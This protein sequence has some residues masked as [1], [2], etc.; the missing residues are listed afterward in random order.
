MY[1]QDLNQFLV[2]ALA[3]LLAVISPGPDFALITRQSFLHGRKSSI[4]TSLGIASG[5]LVHVFY[6]IVGLNFLLTNNN[7]LFYIRI[8]CA[9]YLFYLGLSSIFIN[10][11]PDKI[12]DNNDSSSDKIVISNFKSFKIGFIT[13][14]LNLKATLFFL[15]LYSFILSSNPDTSKF[16]QLSYGIWMMLITGCW[17]M[18]VSWFLTNKFLEKITKDYYLIIN[19]VMGI[20]LI[21]IA[22]RLFID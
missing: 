3:H 14:I 22:I 17:F 9:I 6:C 12:E 2:I 4:Y 5:I 16:L 21:Y 20:V 19:R 7:I 15:S 10:Y 8:V 13:N 18:F 11:K 1:F